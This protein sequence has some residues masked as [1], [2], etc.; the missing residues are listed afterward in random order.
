VRRLFS[1]GIIMLVITTGRG[2]AQPSTRVTKS[3]C[4]STLG[5]EEQALKQ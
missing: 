3:V 2:N 4:L 5:K 1:L